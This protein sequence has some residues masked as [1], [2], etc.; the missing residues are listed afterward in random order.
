MRVLSLALAFFAADIVVEAGVCKPAR[1]TSSQSVVTSSAESSATAVSTA[2]TET[3][4][5]SAESPTSTTETVISAS[6]T[7]TLTSSITLAGTTSTELVS[8]AITEEAST[9]TTEETPTTTTAEAGPSMTPGSIVGTGPVAD[10]TLQGDSTRFIPLSFAPSGSTQTLIFTLVN[11]KLYV[12]VN[13]YLCIT[14]KAEGVLGPLVLCPFDTF[15]STPLVCEREPSGTLACTA[16]A[17][18]C[19]DNGSCRRPNVATAFSQFYVD[20]SQS[21]FFGPPG[22]FAGFTALDLILAQ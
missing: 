13:N 20:S 8:T 19:Q 10:L 14:N 9:T 15:T 5:V 17:T 22:D 1:I 2:V 16:P 18:Y 21:G 4:V 12:G 6:A 7:E 3:P 11:N